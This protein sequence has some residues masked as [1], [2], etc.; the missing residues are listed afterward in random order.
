MVFAR[1]NE[2][3]GDKL[4]RTQQTLLSTP[5]DKLSYTVSGLGKLI[6]YL[7]S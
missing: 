5:W 7:E 2:S 3:D 4:W 1:V 6:F